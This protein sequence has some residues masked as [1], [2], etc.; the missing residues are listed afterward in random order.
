MQDDYN[1]RTQI[2]T[3]VSQKMPNKH[4]YSNQ[5]ACQQSHQIRESLQL[6]YLRPR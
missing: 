3:N 4:F 6:F 5:D 2:L 1:F